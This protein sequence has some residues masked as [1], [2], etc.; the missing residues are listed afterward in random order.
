MREWFAFFMSGRTAPDSVD[1]WAKTLREV[2][3]QP[4]L[5][6]QFLDAGMAAT[7]SKPAALTARI[8]AEQR[9]WPPVLRGLG[10]RV[11]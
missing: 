9:D 10:V 5:V 4:T 3:A 2:L 7:S 8:A 11:E 6:A 1:T